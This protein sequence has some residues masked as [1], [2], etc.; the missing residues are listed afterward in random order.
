MKK[1]TYIV[2]KCRKDNS[3]Y[4]TMHGAIGERKTLCG[5]VLD[6]NWYITNTNVHTDPAT[7]MNLI[8]CKKCLKKVASLRI[9][10]PTLNNKGG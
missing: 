4:G 2:S 6:S 5:K 10:L 9:V 8:T 7:F 3:L 1:I